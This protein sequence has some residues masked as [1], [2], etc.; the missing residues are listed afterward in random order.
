MIDDFLTFNT[1]L[2]RPQWVIKDKYPILNDTPHSRNG[3]SVIGIH[4]DLIYAITQSSVE[5]CN[6]QNSL[7][8]N[9]TKWIHKIKWAGEGVSTCINCHNMKTSKLYT[10]DGYEYKFGICDSCINVHRGVFNN[11]LIGVAYH[12]EVIDPDHSCL[13]IEYNKDFGF[14][15]D[16]NHLNGCY[17]R[18]V[19]YFNSCKQFTYFE[20]ID[21]P[22]LLSCLICMR[23]NCNCKKFLLNEFYKQLTP[24]YLLTTQ[25]LISD[26]LPLVWEIIF[27]LYQA[28]DAV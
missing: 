2:D 20:Y 26:L 13:I 24:K 18:T 14:D 28:L 10:I 1:L 25:L 22:E 16:C 15:C 6:I 19:Y 12:P 27:I 9:P 7:P 3:S 11:V 21:F 5:C 17:G 23:E 4:N 8:L